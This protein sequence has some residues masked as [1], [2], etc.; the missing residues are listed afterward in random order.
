MR[1]VAERAGVSRAL[2]SIVFRDA[3]GAS[4]ETRERVLEAAAAIGYA[5][6]PHAS[7]L[8]RARS[9]LLGVAFSVAEPFHGALLDGIYE[10]AAEGGYEA[11]LSVSTRRR[12]EA[13]AVRSLT[14]ER[15]EGIILVGPT[16]RRSTL[17]EVAAQTPTVVALRPLRMPLVDVVRSDDAAGV[18]Q[19]M[20]HL[21]ALGHRHILHLDGVR[22]PASAERRTAFRRAARRHGV[23]AS[24]VTGGASEEA[25]VSAG[26][27]VG[28]IRGKDRPTAVLAFNDRLALG[29]IDGLESAGVR[30]PQDCSVVGFDDISAA[31]FAH[32]GLTTVRQDAD[33]LGC[34][35]VERLMDRLDSGASS[36]QVDVVAPQLVVRDTT[37]PPPIG[38]RRP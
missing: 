14:A 25:G 36:G 5:P 13:Q 11:V 12:S 15:C 30:V 27:H 3:P 18:G 29:L 21:V 1:D 22:A 35:S 17:E 20:D 26:R 33:T 2:V 32:I 38:L 9:R 10:R 23:E 28:A 31:G 19:A 7:R 24:V 37:A 8:R 16:L 34:R 6:D 4:S